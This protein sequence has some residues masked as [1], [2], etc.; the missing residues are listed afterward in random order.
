[1]SAEQAV[2]Q[3]A[4]IEERVTE[5]LKQLDE[6]DRRDEGEG[7]P[8]PARIEAAL[9][10]LRERDEKLKQ[11]Q[12]Q[13]AARAEPAGKDETP[14]VGLTDPDCVML[15]A[16]GGPTMAGYNVQQAVDTKHKLIV[17]P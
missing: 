12:A 16:K 8:A 1:M 4:K 13:L 6:A 10:R 14:W 5:Y 3:R 2:K 15:K 7:E 11:A 17:A 9:K